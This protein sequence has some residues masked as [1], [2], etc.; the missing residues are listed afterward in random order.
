MATFLQ[1]YAVTDHRQGSE[2]AET[3][4]I[5]AISKR[6]LYQADIAVFC[7]IIAISLTSPMDGFAIS[8]YSKLL[9]HDIPRDIADLLYHL[10]SGRPMSGGA[11][12]SP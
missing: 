3:C 1:H 9:Y 8:R 11:G 6:L 2:P 7:Y 5:T 4:Y 10:P 12:E